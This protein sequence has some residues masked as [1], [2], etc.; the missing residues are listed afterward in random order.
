MRNIVW[1]KLSAKGPSGSSKKKPSNHYRHPIMNIGRAD[2]SLI[3][4]MGISI[5]GKTIWY[6]DKGLSLN[7]SHHTNIV[8]P[9]GYVDQDVCRFFALYR[10]G[11]F[12][13]VNWF[14]SGWHR[15]YDINVGKLLVMPSVLILRMQSTVFETS[16]ST[17][18]NMTKVKWYI[19]HTIIY[20]MYRLY[21]KQDVSRKMALFMTNTTKVQVKHK[22]C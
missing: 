16:W 9:C 5:P 17:H 7:K 3:F 15:W 2:D 8:Y 14:D 11:E 20:I 12:M 6:W 13:V 19:M 1:I 18:G 10:F 4:T 21:S 22:G